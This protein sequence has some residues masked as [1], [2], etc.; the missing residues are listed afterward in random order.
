[1]R[2]RVGLWCSTSTC[3]IQICPNEAPPLARPDSIV[4]EGEVILSI[5]GEDSLSVPDERALLRGKA[6]RKVLLRV[7]SATVKPATFW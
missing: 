1:M 4:H 6:G 3:M 7:K 5:D 2:R